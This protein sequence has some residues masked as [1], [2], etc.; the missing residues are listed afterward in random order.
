MRQCVGKQQQQVERG[1]KLGDMPG[2][3]YATRVAAS[4]PSRAPPGL[5]V[6]VYYVAGSTADGVRGAKHDHL[7]LS[8]FLNYCFFTADYKLSIFEVKVI[9]LA[10]LLFD[11]LVFF[12]ELYY[13]S[14][15][16]LY[17][18]LALM[19]NRRCS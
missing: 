4:Q 10:L 7:S 9:E 16:F 17:S 5:A 14:S 15:V 13:L 3:L 1:E 11:N 2:S 18:L 19:Q 6:G 12:Y 8:R